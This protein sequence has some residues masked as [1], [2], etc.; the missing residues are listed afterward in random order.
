M[1]FILLIGQICAGKR[2]NLL[3]IMADDLN[4]WMDPYFQSTETPNLKRLANKGIVFKNFYTSSPV[5]NPARTALWYGIDPSAT[6]ITDNEQTILN[7]YPQ[8]LGK[9][10]HYTL[11]NA[12]YFVVGMGKLYQQLQVYPELGGFD[13]YPGADPTET[14]APYVCKY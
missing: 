11:K 14:L 3:F 4:V 13:D 7:L 8:M 12:N 9:S 10:L 1:T 2:P 5:C 6:N